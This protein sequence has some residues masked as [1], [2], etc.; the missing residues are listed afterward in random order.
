MGRFVQVAPPT[1][2]LNPHGLTFRL[3]SKRAKRVG[4]QLVFGPY[5]HMV[6]WSADRN[7]A[8]SGAGKEVIAK[9]DAELDRRLLRWR[10]GAGAGGR[11]RPCRV[12]ATAST[13]WRW[14][15]SSWILSNSGV[16]VSGV[17]IFE[18]LPIVLLGAFAGTGFQT[19]T[20]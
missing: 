11:P 4:V 15:S 12:S 20:C 8:L 1:P 6:A 7:A 2:E 9:R 17:V 19:S 16:S 10:R 14:S 13:M 3:V 18:A 5:R